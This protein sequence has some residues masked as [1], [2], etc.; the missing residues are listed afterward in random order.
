MR[1]AAL[2]AALIAPPVAALLAM[3]AAPAK[4]ADCQDAP[5]VIET[6]ECLRDVYAAADRE[7]NRVWPRVI[8]E[9]PSGGVPDLHTEEIRKAQRAWIAFRD[10][11]CE[12]RSKT[13][14]PKYREANRL[15]CLVDLT[16]ARVESL[17]EAYL[18]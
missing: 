16:R 12:A 18:S 14:I 1:R 13:G 17:T 4:A 3:Q 11:E 2:A 7:L 10:A 5:S 15:Q 8:A 9:H 6:V